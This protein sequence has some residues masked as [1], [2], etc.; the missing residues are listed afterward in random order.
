MIVCIANY[1]YP[2]W[3]YFV[4]FISSISHIQEYKKP[5]EFRVNETSVKFVENVIAE[6]ERRGVEAE[7]IYRL[8][9]VSSKVDKILQIVMDPEKAST[10]V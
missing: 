10:Y 7:G 3:I 8:V 2:S 1:C 6:I 5:E 9:G 4:F